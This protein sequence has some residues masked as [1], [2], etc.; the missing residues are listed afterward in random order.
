M[1]WELLFNEW[2][3]K[4]EGL[5]LQMVWKVFEKASGTKEKPL[6]FVV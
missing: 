4:A 5:Y 2:K 6:L 3:R 1:T